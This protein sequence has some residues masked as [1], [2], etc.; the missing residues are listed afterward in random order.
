[1]V[2]VGN[3]EINLQMNEEGC[4]RAGNGSWCEAV[5]TLNQNEGP[6]PLK[7]IYQAIRNEALVRYCYN[8]NDL[9]LTYVAV[10]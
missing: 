4:R 3:P 6:R 9:G 7:R 5:I 1:M 10:D 8:S 2:L